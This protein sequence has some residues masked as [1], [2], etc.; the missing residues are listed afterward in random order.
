MAEE[1]GFVA[2][3][4]VVVVGTIQ[5][6]RIH[7]IR[8]FD[9]PAIVTCNCTS[10]YHLF[11]EDILVVIV[12]RHTLLSSLKRILLPA[13]LNELLACATF[14][15]GPARV[16]RIASARSGASIPEHTISCTLALQTLPARTTVTLPYLD[17]TVHAYDFN[18]FHRIDCDKHVSLARCTTQSAFTNG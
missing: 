2:P 5:W 13:D 18:H 7:A 4:K 12:P 16:I 8:K 10:S 1:A 17:S 14:A 15:T 11:D 6:M 9:A 3:S